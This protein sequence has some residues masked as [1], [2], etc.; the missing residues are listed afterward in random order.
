[1]PDKPAPTYTVEDHSSDLMIRARGRDYLEALANASTAL[2]MESVTAEEPSEAEERHILINGDS[3]DQR[4][5]AFLNEIL[6]LI[7]GCHWVPWRVRHL[8][9][10]KQKGCRSLEAVVVGE[11]LNPA[12]HVFRHDVKA[13]TYHDFAIRQ[14][15]EKTTIQFVCDL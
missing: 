14:D 10:C 3:D 12:R 7:F 11:P 8:T 6:Y 13:V 9:L 5:I 1:M 15:E 4:T 2:V